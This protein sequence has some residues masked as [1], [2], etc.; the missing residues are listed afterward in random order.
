MWTGKV[1]QPILSNERAKE[2]KGMAKNQKSYTPEF[3]QQAVGLYNGR[4]TSYPQLEREYGVNQSAVSG[5]VK[6]LPLPRYHRRKRP[7]S[8]S[9]RL[10]RK[11]GRRAIIEYIEGWYNRKRI[12]S[13]IGYITPQQKEDEGLK[14]AA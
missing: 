5:W 11:E 10:S 8:R 4:G 9:I 13:A 14:E 3:K 12:H 6:Q 7:P 1:E 2:M